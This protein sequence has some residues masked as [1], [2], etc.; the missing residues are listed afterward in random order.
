MLSSTFFHVGT[1]NDGNDIIDTG[2]GDDQF[3][4]E[5]GTIISVP[6]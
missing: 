2:L 4:E 6:D 5:Q 1:V 3:M